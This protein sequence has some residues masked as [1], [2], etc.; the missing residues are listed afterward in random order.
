MVLLMHCIC[1]SLCKAGRSRE[2][3]RENSA[4]ARGT[5]MTAEIDEEAAVVT[6]GAGLLPS[7][8]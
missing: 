2:R 5:V 8:L 3:R 7:L 6:E 1:R 4:D